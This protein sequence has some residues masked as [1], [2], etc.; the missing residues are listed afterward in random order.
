L[1]ARPP[2][3]S[4]PQERIETAQTAADGAINA[5]TV[6]L[7]GFTVELDLIRKL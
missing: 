6:T 3:R 1:P 5:A 2:K 4:P 7:M